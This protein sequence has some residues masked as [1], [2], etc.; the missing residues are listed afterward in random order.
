MYQTSRGGI[1][2]SFLKVAFQALP[3]LYHRGDVPIGHSMYEVA[4]PHKLDER[5]T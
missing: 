5:D 2:V 1:G 3:G 4:L